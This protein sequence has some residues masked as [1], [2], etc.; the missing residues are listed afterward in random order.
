VDQAQLLSY[1]RLLDLR[2]GLLINFHSLL[3]KDGIKRLVNNYDDRY[4]VLVSASN[5]KFTAEIAGKGRRERSEKLHSIFS[6][7]SAGFL[8]VLCG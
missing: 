8:G 5:E 2:V 7:S 1:L 4:D 6:A 3:L